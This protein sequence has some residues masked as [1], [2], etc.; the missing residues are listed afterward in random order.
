MPKA[1]EPKK[2]TY[3]FFTDE[4]NYQIKDA[5]Y[6]DTVRAHIGSI[7]LID[8]K[9][10]IKVY[11]NEVMGENH[12][13]GE[14]GNY[15]ISANQCHVD[16]I[17]TKDMQ[18]KGG[19]V[20]YDE[21]YVDIEI[22]E[23]K[24]HVK[25]SQIF[26]KNNSF[27]VDIPNNVTKLKVG[28]TD[29]EKNG[30]SCVCKDYDLI[31]GI[32]FSCEERKKVVQIC[33]EIWGESKKKEMANHLMACMALETGTSFKPDEGYSSGG[34]TG[35]VQWTG[36]AIDAM[37]KNNKYNN[38][39]TLTKELLSKMK[40][41]EQ[42]DYV[43][44]YFKMW[45]DSGKVINDSLDMYMCI[46][47]PAAVGKEDSFVCYSKENN[48]KFYNANKSIDGEYYIEKSTNS[49][50]VKVTNTV[51]NKDKDEQI[52]KGELR[53]RLKV[54]EVAG[55]GNKT[56][57]LDCGLGINSPEGIV[58]YRIYSDGNIEKH[59]PKTI[60]KGFENKYKYIYHDF[61]KVEH[62]VCN[63][64]WHETIKKVNGVNKGNTKPTHS[65]VVSDN[66]V[67][68]GQTS[69]RVVYE[70]DDVAEYG[71]NKK[72]YFWNLYTCVSGKPKIIIV[73]MPDSL[74]Y[75]KSNIVIKYSFSDTQR[76]FT[77]PGALAGFIGALAECGYD[78]IKTTGSCFREGTCFPSVAHV[79]GKSI[80]TEYIDRPQEIKF[81]AAMEK[82]NFDAQITG[83]NESH[84]YDSTKHDAKHN[85]HLHSGFNENKIVVI[86]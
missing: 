59:I 82:F 19:N 8:H 31:W 30:N 32:K 69:R 55:L 16:I 47:C 39:K 66:Q 78:D 57:M 15:T 12:F 37:N 4:K 17:L 35:L 43:K 79:N 26:V 11:D 38:G 52:T 53:P 73:K 60:K 29:V 5:K 48:L 45:I 40:I 63:V 10:K 54:K 41:L 65:N 7:G 1:G 28:K 72:V 83:T 51:G 27:K 42:L 50:G 64:D 58:I 14:V 75:S 74:D 21:V 77:S 44:L 86:S 24:A 56:N 71:I 18:E 22:M 20:F 84:K 76:R 34:A 9:V 68:E 62:E 13:L 85:D 23:T 3:I 46:W 81:I 25:S 33:S 36:T 49:K 61:K 6:G 80:D 2:I 67:S 70:N